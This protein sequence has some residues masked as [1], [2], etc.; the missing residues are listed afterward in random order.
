MA[1]QVKAPNVVIP[2]QALFEVMSDGVLITD[3]RGQRS[4]SN[5]ALNDLIGGD[6]RDPIGSNEPPSWLP[7]DQH[8]RYRSL[9]SS[10]RKGGLYDATL[11][12][13]WTVLSKSGPSRSVA[14]QIIPMNGSGSP[15]SALLWLIIASEPVPV[16][17][18]PARLAQLEESLRRIA[19][20]VTRA[21]L[22]VARVVNTRSLDHD[23]LAS[24]SRR[25]REV[26]GQ[27]L[28]GH[29]VISIA[30]ELGVSEHTVRN[31]IKSMF[32]KVDVHSQAELVSLV[33][34]IQNAG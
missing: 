14:I 23:E 10:I 12:L 30:R 24:L 15:V 21:G 17:A 28:E 3:V 8:D 32:R 25:E 2:L 18:G 7:A 19:G 16:A 27:L 34:K 26:L 20:E 31:H 11:S 1:A 9:V 6:A 29:R 4:Y 5:R 33:R 13:E 22:D